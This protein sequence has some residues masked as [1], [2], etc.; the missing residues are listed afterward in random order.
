MNNN[1]SGTIPQSMASLG[2]REFDVQLA[3]V[4]WFR[5]MNNGLTGAVRTQNSY[6]TFLSALSYL[7]VTYATTI[8]S[9]PSPLRSAIFV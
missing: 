2:P 6:C 5:Q 7:A 3:G 8:S 1:L 9:E 4:P